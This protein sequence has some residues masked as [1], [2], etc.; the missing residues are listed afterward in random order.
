M[1]NLFNRLHFGVLGFLLALNVVFVSQACMPRSEV[2]SL[3]EKVLVFE[4]RVRS[5]V[6]RVDVV[7]S[8]LLLTLPDAE[9][10]I[11]VAEFAKGKIVLANALDAKD[12]CLQAIHEGTKTEADL[13]QLVGFV[14]QAVQSVISVVG[15]FGADKDFVRSET[16]RSMSLRGGV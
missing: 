14:V 4:Q 7:F 15:A 10:A 13:T 3:T 9:R 1:S 8:Q 12:A 6:D 2:A 16:V 5:Q 11:A